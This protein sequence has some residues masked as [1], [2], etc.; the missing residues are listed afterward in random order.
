MGESYSQYQSNVYRCLGTALYICR[1][2]PLVNFA[3]RCHSFCTECIFVLA[4]SH[5]F[6]SVAKFGSVFVKRTVKC[7]SKALTCPLRSS[8]GTDMC[9]MYQWAIAGSRTTHGE[10]LFFSFTLAKYVILKPPTRLWCNHSCGTTASDNPRNACTSV[11]PVLPVERIPSLVVFGTTYHLYV[12]GRAVLAG[13]HR[14]LSPSTY[15]LR[16]R[17]VLRN[18]T[19]SYI[20]LLYGLELSNHGHSKLWDGVR[21]TPT[22]H[23]L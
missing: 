20:Q 21:M 3:V 4:Q 7:S 10:F 1:L 22:D 11:I 5:D 15:F 14:D 6:L 16:A 23:R 12:S 2:M 8:G 19:R 13:A 18:E 9:C 17:V